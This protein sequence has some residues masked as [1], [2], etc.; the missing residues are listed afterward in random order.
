MVVTP[1]EIASP[2]RRPPARVGRLFY[3]VKGI[4]V[5]RVI[6]Y[7]DGY[8]LYY[9]L[10]TKKWKWFYWLNVQAMARRLLKPHQTLVST[11]Y[12]TTIVKHPPDKQRRQAVFLEAL[13]TL[14]DLQIFYGH[15]LSNPITCRQCG[16]TYT[17]YHEKMT[18][19]NIAV[20][21]MCDA[22]QD[23][24]DMALLISGDGD[25]VGP[26]KAM[27]R[28]F[29]QKRVVVAFP[30]ARFSGALKAAAHAHTFIGPNVLSNSVFPDQVVKPDGFVLHRPA[31]WR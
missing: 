16:H 20:E 2:G 10:R 3:L 13:R 28:L 23:H 22:F 12:F 15:W 5:Q 17:G 18:D 26:V 24:L 6:A 14:N 27:Q 19:V 25:L 9:G 30:P 7:I 8:N 4:P 21:L 1:L 31:E 29:P 11:K